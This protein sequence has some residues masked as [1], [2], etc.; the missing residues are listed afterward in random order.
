M[1][2]TKKAAPR[3]VPR[4]LL[5]L[6]HLTSLPLSYLDSRQSEKERAS[7][8]TFF[9]LSYTQTPLPHSSHDQR[10]TPLAKHTI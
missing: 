4:H 10:A 1:T 8:F 5:F 7:F 6:F 3:S 9:F 2:S